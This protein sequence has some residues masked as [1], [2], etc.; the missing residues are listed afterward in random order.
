M[1][2]STAMRTK[3]SSNRMAAVRAGL[4]LLLLGIWMAL[5]SEAASESEDEIWSWNQTDLTEFTGHWR[6]FG[7]RDKSRMR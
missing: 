4:A 3:E 6:P 7:S 5:A 2:I 1:R